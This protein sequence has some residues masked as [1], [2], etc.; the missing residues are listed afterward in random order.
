MVA[1]SVIGTLGTNGW[2]RSDVATS[3][4]VSDPESAI[5]GTAGCQPTTLASDTAG[6]ALTC[7]ATSAGQGGP[8]SATVTLR[9][10]T[11]PPIVS[12]GARPTFTLTQ[13]PA[14]VDAAV[15]DATSGAV[16]ATT[17]VLVSTD[18]SGPRTATVSALDLAGNTG[19][20]T[21][22]YDVTIPTCL[23]KVPTIIGTSASETITGTSGADVILGLSGADT[24]NGA[25]GD[26]VIC[27]GDG[28]DLVY[29]GDGADV[30]AG[31]DGA[32]DLNGGLKADT[33]DG[34]AGSDSLRGDAGADRCTSGELRMSSCAVL[35]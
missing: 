26:D 31:G 6:T 24:I 29:G 3:W 10:D 8:G 2:Y 5:T 16:S 34:G 30:I 7:T 33:L 4:S 22:P 20:T 12:C 17:S 35:Y 14:Y 25:G 9:R 13:F 32:D 15:T 21:C 11:T 27:A 28:A 23:G 19:T 18:G 1:P